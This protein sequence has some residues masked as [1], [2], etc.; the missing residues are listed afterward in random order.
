MASGNMDLGYPVLDASTQKAGD[1]KSEPIIADGKV[2]YGKID[3]MT[4]DEYI[5]QITIADVKTF[6]CKNMVVTLA[7]K[8]TS[9]ESLTPLTSCKLIG[10][11][12]TELT[13]HHSLV[14]SSTVN[15]KRN[16]VITHTIQFKPSPYLDG[17]KVESQQLI[18]SNSSAEYPEILNSNDTK[19]LFFTDG[20]QVLGS[21]MLPKNLHLKYR[22]LKI[23]HE[24]ESTEYF[25]D[26]TIGA[27]S[28]ILDT[29][30]LSK[31]YLDFDFRQTVK[32]TTFYTFVESILEIIILVPV[33][34]GIILAIIGFLNTVQFYKSLAQLIQRR[35]FHAI[36]W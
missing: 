35:Y 12:F 23:I 32:T 13:L 3:G 14:D 4:Y 26:Q 11:D 25:F 19:V 28:P 33:C 17:I 10:S 8:E 16:S 36:E 6:L 9:T 27:I 24:E 29:K 20:E 34:S 1:E 5:A 15:L 7:Y 21:K 30:S 18:D 2:L 22:S 31:I